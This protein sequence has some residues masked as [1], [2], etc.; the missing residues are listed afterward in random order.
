MSERGEIKRIGARAQKNSGRGS[1]Q[2]G[3]ATNNTF[4]IDIKEYKK[5]YSISRDSWAKICTDSF[6][7]SPEKEPMLLLVLGDEQKTRLAVVDYAFIEEME[8]VYRE[9]KESR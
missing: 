5:S 3:D 6:R 8:E 1:Y 4:V 7:T 9:W 2:K